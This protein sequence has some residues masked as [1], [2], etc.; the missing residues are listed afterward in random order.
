VL[1]SPVA[2]PVAGRPAASP[3]TPTVSTVSSFEYRHPR[4]KRRWNLSTMAGS[5]IAGGRTTLSMS[6]PTCCAGTTCSSDEAYAFSNPHRAVPA[7][8]PPHDPRRFR[9]CDRRRRCRFERDCSE[10]THKIVIETSRK[11]SMGAY[12]TKCVAR[13]TRS[14]TAFTCALFRHRKM[15]LG[16]PVGPCE[17]YTWT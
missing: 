17:R 8:P 9:T 11:A 1:G 14:V 3:S 13:A 5:N 2:H 4:R 6:A 15:A 7:R 16:I 10:R 12:T